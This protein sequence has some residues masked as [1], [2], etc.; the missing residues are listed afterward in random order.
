MSNNRVIGRS[1]ALP[2]HLSD[3]VAFFKRTTLGSPVVMGRRTYESVGRPLP[4][5]RNIVLSATGYLNNEVTVVPDIDSALT[6]AAEQ[7]EID[8]VE[9]CFVV[10]G[11]RVYAETLDR[12]DRLYCTLVDAEIDGDTVFP[13]FDWG[14]W[15]TIEKEDFVANERNTYSFSIHIMERA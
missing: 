6:V 10:G 2:W 3:D 12:A 13:S 5:R 4:G 11:A 9:E 8:S 1:N 14:C 7:C 15:R